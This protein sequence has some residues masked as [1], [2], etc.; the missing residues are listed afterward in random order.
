M[1]TILQCKK[2][3]SNIQIIINN[4]KKCHKRHKEKEKTKGW[5]TFPNRRRLNRSG[6]L[7]QITTLGVGVGQL[8]GALLWSTGDSMC[9][10]TLKV[11]SMTGALWL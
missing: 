7:L 3:K 8:Q 9:C 11:L 10:V 2:K 4:N 6:N 1:S 5:R